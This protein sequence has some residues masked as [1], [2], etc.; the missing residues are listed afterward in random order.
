MISENVSITCSIEVLPDIFKD[1][2]SIE[3]R[4]PNSQF[5]EDCNGSRVECE[6]ENVVKRIDDDRGRTKSLI[7]SK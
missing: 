3:W 7:I 2:V 1:G 4:G 5:E 6:N